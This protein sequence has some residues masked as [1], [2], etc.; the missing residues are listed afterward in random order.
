[1]NSDLGGQA[2]PGASQDP[3][4]CCYLT[5]LNNLG[6][7]AYSRVGYLGGKLICFLLTSGE[8][9]RENLLLQAGCSHSVVSRSK[10]FGGWESATKSG[11][12]A[13]EVAQSCPTP[14]GNYNS[15]EQ[16][17]RQRMRWLDGITYSMDVSLSKLPE[18]VMDREAWCAAVQ[19]SQRVGHN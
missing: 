13:S 3:L 9:L 4:T 5:V 8:C 1:M 16:L 18:L 19:G 12:C 11:C 15:L 14:C 10:H 7:K 17:G 2:G 6:V